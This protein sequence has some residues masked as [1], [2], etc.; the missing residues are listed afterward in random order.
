MS[1]DVRN[2]TKHLYCVI[3]GVNQR[4]VH[5]SSLNCHDDSALMS[6]AVI[7]RAVVPGGDCQTLE[8]RGRF[9]RGLFSCAGV[10]MASR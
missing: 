6:W 10:I 8:L 1:P 3:Y 7:D 9:R 4:D 2:F 5:D